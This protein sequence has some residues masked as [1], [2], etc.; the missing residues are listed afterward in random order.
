MMSPQ[1]TD[2]SAVAS[3][4]DSVEQSIAA[5][6]RRCHRARDE[7]TLVPISKRQPIEKL[8]AAFSAG[9]RCFGE[10]IVQEAATKA[11][12]LPPDLEWHFIG[13][14][15]SNKTRPAVRLFDVF[16]SIDRLKIARAIDKEAGLQGRRPVGFLQ[17]NVG[18]ESSK[19]G[20][21]KERVIDAA[22]ELRH[23]DNLEIVGLMAL[24]PY[25]ENPEN[26]RRWFRQLRQL[27]DELA[28]RGFWPHS[29]GQLS[30]G[31][32]HDLE[33]AVSEGST[34]LRIGTSIFGPRPS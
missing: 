9:V 1:G 15:Q 11:A 23:L 18:D 3:C 27:R 34:H 2:S 16:H 8:R 32:S 5:A 6:C 26:A 22:L 12:E 13:H 10:N 14:L 21:S 17:V 25:E 7:I 31:M 30:M 24:P 19:H 33:V 4:L 20:F 28:D 29:K